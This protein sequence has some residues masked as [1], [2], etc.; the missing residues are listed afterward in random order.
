MLTPQQIDEITLDTAVFGGY[1]T[2]SVDAFLEPLIEDYG[3]LY[4]ENALLK[5]KM[6]ILVEKLEEYRANEASLRNA[7][8]NAQKT[9]DQMILDAEAKCKKLL[10]DAN[11]AA[12][13]TQ[14][15]QVRQEA[16]ARISQVQEQLQSCIA[17]LEGIKTGDSSSQPPEAQATDDLAAEIAANLQNLIG[18]DDAS[19]PT[20][21]RNKNRKRGK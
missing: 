20:A 4:K 16:A 7:M 3:T 21:N 6:R 12:I 10:A 5:S 9:C 2:K 17:V 1:D 19:A 14:P 13:S 11:A 18:S 8:D 15:E